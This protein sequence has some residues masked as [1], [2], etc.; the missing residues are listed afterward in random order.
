VR[1]FG[2]SGLLSVLSLV[3]VMASRFKLGAAHKDKE[4]VKVHFDIIVKT[5]ENVPVT[6]NVYVQWKRGKKNENKGESKH[7]PVKDKKA[8]FEELLEISATLYKV[9]KKG[10][11]SKN[12]S[13]TLKEV[14]SLHSSI[15]FL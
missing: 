6:G 5:A 7:V 13:I 1:P 3:V 14:C 12:I 15:H 2:A 4:C 11:E 9:P 10:Y 8:V